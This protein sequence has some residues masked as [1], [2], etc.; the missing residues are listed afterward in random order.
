MKGMTDDKTL[1]LAGPIVVI[2]AIAC[3]QIGAHALASWPTSSLLWYLNLEVFRSFQ[4]GLDVGLDRLLGQDGLAQS[5]WIMVPLLALICA[6]LTLRSRLPLAI[7]SH[8]SLLYSAFAA[9]Q[10][11]VYR[12]AGSWDPSVLLASAILLGS[13]LSS[14]ISHRSYWREIFS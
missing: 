13:I 6:G 2:A 5:L 11:V 1:E 3:A 4:Y 10:T 12:L 14:T 9:Y 7:A 8:L